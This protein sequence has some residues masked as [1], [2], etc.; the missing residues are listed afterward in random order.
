M[1]LSNTKCSDLRSTAVP[2]ELGRFHALRIRNC[3]EVI[4]LPNISVILP[5][6]TTHTLC[7]G[8]GQELD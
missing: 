4:A 6:G 5:A 2:R 3:K 8:R 7:G 1:H